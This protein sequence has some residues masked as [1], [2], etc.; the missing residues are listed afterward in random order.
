MEDS[1]YKEFREQAEEEA[2]K[3]RLVHKLGVRGIKDIF[4]FIEQT[5]GYLLIRYPLGEDSLEGFATLYKKEVLIVTNSSLRLGREIFTAA[6]ELAHHVFDISEQ[7]KQ[8]I[9]DH[10]DTVG[11]FNKENL[12]EFRADCFAANFLMPKEGITKA[13]KELGKVSNELDYFDVIQLQIEFGVSY[14]AMLRR[15]CD[16]EVIDEGQ[17]ARLQNYYGHLGMSLT[18]LFRRVNADTD[19]IERSKSIH[20]PAKYF[21]FLES[22]YENKYIPYHSLEQALAT[23]RKQPEELG[24]A[25]NRDEGV[26]KEDDDDFDLD[27][28][29]GELD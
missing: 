11:N 19:L 13:V 26:S 20:I 8:L 17:R 25:K 5:L 23:I 4:Q 22:N 14:A 16:L 21:K 28:L 29:L 1:Q 2:E 7:G 12:I 15:L 3:L 9:H 6:H 24:F 10:G 27:E 18:G